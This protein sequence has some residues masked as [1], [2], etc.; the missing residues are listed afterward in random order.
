[1]FFYYYLNICSL[2]LL[3][4]KRKTSVSP[5][6]HFSRSLYHFLNSFHEKYSPWAFRIKYL[7]YC[8]FFPIIVPSIS[9]IPHSLLRF[10]LLSKKKFKNVYL[11]NTSCRFNFLFLPYCQ[12]F[13]FFLIL[14]SFTYD[15]SSIFKKIPFFFS[16]C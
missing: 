12:K 14:P 13:I 16:S 8:F 7:C 5:W 6:C 1:M 3:Y 9:N 4:N 10:C 2:Q 11:K 15:S